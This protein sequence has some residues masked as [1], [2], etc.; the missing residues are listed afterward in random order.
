M[1]RCQY[2]KKKALYKKYLW[3]L[4]LKPQYDK[5][6]HFCHFEP[7]AKRRPNGLQGVAKALYC[8]IELFSLVILSVSEISIEFKTHFKFKVKKST[9]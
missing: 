6:G 9:L 7:F 3:I 8:H 4:R 1:T 2:N 5:L